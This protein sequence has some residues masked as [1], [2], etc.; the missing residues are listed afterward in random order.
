[1]TKEG[2]QCKDCHEATK[3]ISKIE[4]RRLSVRTKNRWH[5]FENG[6]CSCNDYF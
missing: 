1:M 4:N 2:T 3:V 6:Q 5:H